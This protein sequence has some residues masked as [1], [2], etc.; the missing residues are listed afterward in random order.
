[1]GAPQSF[2][3][4]QQPDM[5]FIVTDD[6]LVD[7]TGGQACLTLRSSPSAAHRG[8]FLEVE[9]H[10]RQGPHA[11]KTLLASSQCDIQGHSPIALVLDIRDGRLSMALPQDIRSGQQWRHVDSLPDNEDGTLVMDLV[12]RYKADSSI[13]FSRAVGVY[14]STEALAG[15]RKRQNALLHDAKS[16]RQ[17]ARPW[18]V[19]PKHT[20]VHVATVSFQEGD[21]VSS[22]V[23]GVA[24]LLAN[25]GVPCTLY[26]AHCD[27]GLRGLI[28]PPEFLLA[29]VQEQDVLFQNYSIYD[30]FMP[31]LSALPCKKILYYH[32]ITPPALIRSYRPQL[33]L[34]CEKGY[35]Q[36]SLVPSFPKLMA[37]SLVSSCVLA[38][39]LRDGT[40]E[41]TDSCGSERDPAESITVC[42]PL[43]GIDHIAGAGS[44]PVDVP[45][46]PVRLLYVGRI[47]PHKKIEDLLALF[48]E[49]HRLEADS[50]LLLVGRPEF[51]EYADRLNRLV[52]SEFPHLTSKVHWCGHVPQERLNGMY[53]SASAFVTMTEHEGFCVPLV[54]AMAFDVPVFAFAE[55]AVTETLGGAGFLYASKDFPSIAAEMR[56]VLGDE[57][58]RETML[59]AQRRRVRQIAREADGH[60]VWQALEEVL[61]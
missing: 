52:A 3:K 8:C 46:P 30:P 26:A 57:A 1:M 10:A 43:I 51:P 39:A 25:N 59:A 13:A 56:R 37:N 31:A 4:T 11:P 6:Y 34:E 29:T 2:V 38:E 45:L 33:A 50:C 32:G 15:C 12:L 44:K 54:E 58:Q 9:V 23:L 5:P 47:V 40:E 19:W 7:L 27:L 41:P 55:P 22:F 48:H 60:H 36:M 35:E 18:F 24:K 42:P 14:T 20:H 17:L 28:K 49:Y 61:D 53:A 16:T 21:A